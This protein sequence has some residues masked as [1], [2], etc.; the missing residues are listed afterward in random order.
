MISD[1]TQVDPSRTAML[2]RQYTAD[3]H[4]RFDRVRQ[5]QRKELATLLLLLLRSRSID[6]VLLLYNQWLDLAIRVGIL[7]IF[8]DGRIIMRPWLSTAI[9]A[10]YQLGLRRA[11]QDKGTDVGFTSEQKALAASGFM[12]VALGR[13]IRQGKVNLLVTRAYENLKGITA[14]MAAELNRTLADGLAAGDSHRQIIADMN[15]VIVRTYNRRVKAGAS[16]ELVGAAAEGQ[17]DGY[18]D[19]G[20]AEVGVEAELIFT[21]AGDNRVCPRCRALEGKRFI[22]KQARGLIPI[23]P[24]CRCSLR[25][26][27]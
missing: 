17:L 5:D 26:V 19:L 8:T 9:L 27:K 18:E 13:P 12:A 20:V 6:Y 21:T 10:A 24:A 15:K 25:A 2:R 23:H 1:V 16:A 4:R 11:Y 22:I 7:Q 3:L 14:V